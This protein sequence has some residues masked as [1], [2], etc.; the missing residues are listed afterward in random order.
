MDRKRMTTNQK[1]VKAAREKRCIKT[2]RSGWKNI[3]EHKKLNLRFL[4]C[5]NK[6]LKNK[7][8]LGLNPS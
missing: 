1:R 4:F 2:K 6:N 7:T 8:D 3:I 5:P